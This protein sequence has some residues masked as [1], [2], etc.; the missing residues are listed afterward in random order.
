AYIGL[1]IAGL[2][3]NPSTQHLFVASE[4]PGPFN[5]WVV[6][7]G[8]G[9]AVLGGFVVSI[10]GV[11]ALPNGSAS[12]EADCD[13]HLW[14]ID[15]SSQIV[16]EFESGETG[17]CVNDIPWLPENPTSVTVSDRRSSPPVSS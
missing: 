11:P 9:Y 2:A 6:N 10:G 7:P 5:I 1:G 8:S 14:V 3:Y 4:F 17:W 15:A 13:G 12:L 16:Y